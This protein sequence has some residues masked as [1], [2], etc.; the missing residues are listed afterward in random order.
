MPLPCSAAPSFLWHLWLLFR[1]STFFRVLASYLQTGYN[2]SLLNWRSWKHVLGEI[3]SEFTSGCRL[4]RL[5]VKGFYSVSFNR[6]PGIELWNRQLVYISASLTFKIVIFL[7]SSNI[8]VKYQ[9]TLALIWYTHNVVKLPCFPLEALVFRTLE[10]GYSFMTMHDR[11]GTSDRSAVV[12]IITVTGRVIWSSEQYSVINERLQRETSH[13]HGRDGDSGV[14][15]AEFSAGS[16][17]SPAPS[18]TLTLRH[19]DTRGL[20][21]QGPLL[22]GWC[23][24][25]LPWHWPGTWTCG[26]TATSAD[27]NNRDS[28]CPFV[29]NQ[30]TALKV[31]LILPA[32]TCRADWSDYS[33]ASTECLKH[34]S[35][36]SSAVYMQM[37]E[38]KPDTTLW[39]KL[40][41]CDSWSWS[42]RS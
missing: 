15:W 20:G 18:S 25:H 39:K 8:V 36:N 37:Q 30:F 7:R 35:S 27:P 31:L 23:T 2:R 13:D 32:N 6:V 17:I 28:P 16:G 26:R 3:L 22:R 42:C 5:A 33:W 9:K 41:S 29:W 11:E 34:L 38:M 21:V 12:R 24:T 19:W 4:A 14:T 40:F 1:G 10:R